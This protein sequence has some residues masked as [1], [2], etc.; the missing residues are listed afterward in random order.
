[1]KIA[2]AI[3]ENF[4]FINSIN[5]HLSLQIG[6]GTLSYAILNIEDKKYQVLKHINFNIS[7]EKLL[8]ELLL[9]EIENDTNLKYKYASVAFQYQSFRSM[10]VPESLFDHKNLKAFLKFHHDVDDK[11]QIKSYFIKLA[12]AFVIFSIPNYIEEI[13]NTHFAN[14]KYMH[15]CIPFINTS[16][17]QASKDNEATALHIN[18]APDFFDVLI[19]RNNKIQLYNSFFYKK[20]TDVV[21][22]VSNILNLF[23]LK[24]DNTGLYI[25]GELQAKTELQTE[26]E[27]IFKSIK[28]EKYS[29]DFSYAPAFSD[30]EQYQFVN[31]LNLYSCE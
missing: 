14:V 6:P 20:Y 29:L 17:H 18:F 26:L 5:Y 21:Y 31:L 9:T 25:T 11:D 4:S 24:P 27:K 22:F 7:A 1:M 13:V 15:H 30:L 12:E 8:K 3:E 23:S 16:L 19:V 28:F 10:L 2:E